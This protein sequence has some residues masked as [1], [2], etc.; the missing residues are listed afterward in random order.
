LEHA[1]PVRAPG[2]SPN[3]IRSGIPEL[4]MIQRPSEDAH[5]LIAGDQTEEHPEPGR[6]QAFDKDPAEILEVVQ[7]RFYRAAFLYQLL[8]S[9]WMLWRGAHELVW[10]NRRIRP[11][12]SAPV[13]MQLRAQTEQARRACLGGWPRLDVRA[14]AEP[15]SGDCLPWRC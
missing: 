11:W 8:V 7:E 2:H 10:S 9:T 14:G 1:E 13:R 3:L 6:S 12:L 4:R 15:C 5:D